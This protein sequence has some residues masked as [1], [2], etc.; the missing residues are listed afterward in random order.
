MKTLSYILKA[1]LGISLIAYMIHS[2]KLNLN[3]ISSIKDKYYLLILV[4]LILITAIMTTYYRWKLLLSGQGIHFKD[5]ELFS[6]F[7]I[8]IFFSSILPGV[9]SGD[10]IKS[11]YI[12]KKAS[13]KKTP[14]LMTV[15]L[16]R[17]IGLMGLMIICCVGFIINIDI[18]NKHNA[19]KTLAI[20][21]GLS[22]IFLLIFA[23]I[24]L[25][26]RIGQTKIF[27][28]TINHLPFSN[29][30]RSLYEAFHIYR[31]KVSTLFYSLLISI[32]NHALNI[33]AF[34]I[35]TKA[36]GFDILDIKSYL[37][38]VPTG[39]LTSAIPI[40][41]AG[42]GVGQAAF[43]KLFEWSTGVTTT[44]GADAATIWQALC[45]FIYMFGVYFYI[46]YQRT[47]KE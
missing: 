22:L 41:P 31:G 43:L 30:S 26:R 2:D 10:I 3:T 34:F 46:T 40:T 6:I 25:S 21:M 29:L 7:Y 35:I 8:G 28:Y 44:I 24:G 1:A 18:V 5:K 4:T 39:M 45:L 16:D 47:L 15:I 37:F 27:N 17:V 23:I 38:I 20:I 42:I 32:F 12:M 19:L 36:L 9:V 13:D 33:S 14:A 11:S